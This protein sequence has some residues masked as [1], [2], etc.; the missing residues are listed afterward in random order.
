MEVSV[1]NQTYV[2]APEGIVVTAAKEVCRGRIL[3]R[4]QGAGPPLFE[5]NLEV[6]LLGR[7]STYN[8]CAYVL[9]R[10]MTNIL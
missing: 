6:R 3:G 2:T 10:C 7:A 1:F 5:C 8:F 9:W 4:A